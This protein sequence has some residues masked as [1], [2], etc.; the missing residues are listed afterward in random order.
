MT[1]T[2]TASTLFTLSFNGHQT[3]S[4]THPVSA[5]DLKTALN[6]LDTVGGVDVARTDHGAGTPL[7]TYTIEFMPMDSTESPFTE[8]AIKNFGNVP[9]IAAGVD[10][11]LTFGNAP[12]TTEGESPFRANIKYAALSA[13]HTTAFDQNGVTDYD[14]LDN[15]RYQHNT[16]FNI[17]ARDAFSNEIKDE[18]LKEVQIIETTATGTLGG[19]F[20]VSFNGQSFSL[21]FKAGINDLELAL[22]G[23]EG[24]GAVTVT[25]NS[26]NDDSGLDADV[27]TGLDTIN[28]GTTNPTT[29]YGIGDWIR[30]GTGGEVFTVVSVTTSNPFV[31]TVS[32]A[33]SGAS[34]TGVDMLY[35]DVATGTYKGY[36]Y[37]V[38]FD[39]NLGDLEALTVDST[40][41]T[42]AGADVTVTSCN[43]YVYQT[44]TTDSTGAD[45]NGDIGGTFYLAYNGETTADLS[46]AIS[47][48]DLV[49]A[50][51]GLDSIY[52]VSVTATTPDVENAQS[53]KITF[54]AVA[55]GTVQPLYAEGHL[56]TTAGEG[57]A[58][59]TVSNDPTDCAASA[60]S[61]TTAT[62]QAGRQG[63]N[64]VVKL[65]GEDTASGAVSHKS[66][67]VYTAIYNSPK[68]GDYSMAV[69]AAS[70]GGLTGEY[71]NNRWLFG[72]PVVTR[73][74][75]TVDFSWTSD[76]IITPTGKD[77]ISV[78]WT[79][80]IQAAF[81]EVYTFTVEGNDGARLWINDELLFDN[82]ETEVSD[83]DGFST[84]TGTTSVTLTADMLVDI[85]LEYRENTGSAK[86]KLSWSSASQPITV[87]PSNRLF[88]S[89][90]AIKSS[91]FSVTPT[92]IEPTAPTSCSL[93]ISAWNSVLVSWDSPAN[94]GGTGVTGYTVEWWDEQDGYGTDEVQELVFGDALTGS[95]VLTHNG[96]NSIPVAITASQDT[97]ATVIRDFTTVGE[98]SVSREDDTGNNLIKFVI[99][100]TSDSGDVSAIT[101]DGS[102]L[103]ATDF[104]ACDDAAQV[105]GAG[106]SVGC[107]AGP[108]YVQGVAGS[109]VSSDTSITMDIAAGA[110]YE[111]TIASA[112]QDSAHAQ[113]FGVRVFATN[114]VGTGVPCSTN[115]LK[116]M[117]VPD[118]PA[119]V[120]LN[121]VAGQPTS[122]NVHFTFVEYPEDR[123]SAVTGFDIIYDTSADFSSA[124]TK[125]VTVS[126][127]S[128]SSSRQ[129]DIAPYATVGKQY[130]TYTVTGLDAGTVYYV[131]VAATNAIGSGTGLAASPA[132]L[133]PGAQP[134]ALD[135]K[136][137]VS[138]TTVPAD[139]SVTVLESS[140]S[141]LVSFQAPDV[142]NGFIPEKYQVEWWSANP[143]DEIAT[144][145]LTHD[146]NEVGAFSI[147]YNGETTDTM[148]V[149]VDESDMEKE[150][151][152]LTSIRS[153]H[154]EH[155][156]NANSNVWTV[157]FLSETPTVSNKAM[158]VTFNTK[159]NTK[160]HDSS[161]WVV[162]HTVQT[163]TVAGGYDSGLVIVTDATQSFFTYT[164]TGLTAGTPYFVRVSSFNSLGYSVPQ[165]SIPTSLAPPMQN[166][167]EPIST[168]V[169]VHS[170]QALKVLWNHPDSNG[171]DTI[172]KYK[173]EWDSFASF[174]SASGSPLGSHTKILSAPATDCIADSCYYVIG[175]L[176]KGTDYYVRVYAFNSY[177]YSATAGTPT[178]AFESPKTSADPPASVTLTPS[179][180]SSLAVSFPATSDNGGGTITS[181]KVEWDVVSHKADKTISGSTDQS[182]LYV[183]YEVQTVTSVSD[184]YDLTGGFFLAHHE[185]A[186]AQ[187]SVAASANEVKEALEALPSIGT[188][189]VSRTE[190]LNGFTW[191]ITF[192]TN[193]GHDGW[194]GNVGPLSVST[195]TNAFAWD[196]TNYIA[197][198]AAT[199]KSSQAAD[200]AG[201]NNVLGG[202]NA[203]VELAVPVHAYNGYEQ[204]KITSSCNTGSATVGGSFTLSFGGASTNALSF[205]ISAADLEVQLEALG[206]TGDVRVGR[207]YDNTY[208]NVFS[209]S[210]YVV[211]LEKLGNQPMIS[212]DYSLVTCSAGTANVVVTEAK[213]GFLPAMDSNYKGE[214]IVSGDAISGS[215]ITHTIAS[216]SKD[217]EYH[218]RVS[219]F[220]G[221]GST[222][223]PT[224]Y[225]TPA[226]AA[227]ATVP[228]SPSAVTVKAA[229]DA[230]VKVG[231]AAPLN[232][233]GS[234]VTKYKVEWDT[235]PGSPEVQTITS[236]SDNTMYGTFKLTFKTF[237][238]GAIPFDS[239]EVKMKS[240]LEALQSV[241]SVAVSRSSA[242]NGYVWTVTFSDNVGDQP[243]LIAD[244]SSLGGSN[245]NVVVSEV[246][247]GTDP[248]FDQGT[249]GI[250]T[251]PLGSSEVNAPSEVQKIKTSSLSADVGGGF[252][253]HFM[254]QQSTL[255]SYDADETA[256]KE[257][258]ESM[259]TVVGVTVSMADVSEST[260]PV[261]FASREWS[262]TFTGHTGDLP[263]LLVSTVNGAS[264]PQYPA[265]VSTGGT[266]TGTGATVKVTEV[267]A[268]SVPSTFTTPVSLS[269]GTTHF[270][271]VSSYNAVGWSTASVA[272]FGVAPA[273]T[274]PTVP[275]NVLVSVLST[276]E[277]AVSWEAPAKTGGDAVV[278]YAIQW[279]VDAN[280]DSS[281]ST[282]VVLAVDGQSS[283]ST[284]LS[285]LSA[286]QQYAVRVLAYNNQG[287]SSS[288]SAVPIEF[289][290]EV[291][292]FGFS[293]TSTATT[294]DTFVVQYT[295]AA[296]TQSQ[297]TDFNSNT[298]ISVIESAAALEAAMNALPNLGTVRVTRHDYSADPLGNGK[299]IDTSVIAATFD[300]SDGA[301]VDH[302]GADEVTVSA[303]FY[304][305]VYTGAP[306]S[307]GEGGGTVITNLAAGDYFAI[308]SGTANKI[309]FA[310]TLADANGGTQVDLG[311]VGAGTAHTVTLTVLPFHVVY[312]V[313]FVGAT[314]L[315]AGNLADN[316]LDI[317]KTGTD[318]T[319]I[320]VSTI[321]QGQSSATSL[322]STPSDAI[323]PSFPT[324]VALS[325][326]SKKELG[327]T[328]SAPTYTGGAPVTK[329]LV[330]WDTSYNIAASWASSS[331]DY[332]TG[333]AY[334]FS[335]VVTGTSFQITD[336]NGLDATTE[337]WTNTASKEVSNRFDL[338]WKEAN[339]DANGFS[340]ITGNCASN[341]GYADVATNYK[342][343]Y[344]TASDF[345]S[346]LEYSIRMLKNTLEDGT[347]DD[348]AKD[349]CADATACKFAF[350]QEVQSFTLS[351]N[352]NDAIDAGTFKMVY[353]GSQSSSIKVTP[354]LNSATVTI[355]NFTNVE[356]G[357]RDGVDAGDYIRISGDLY[358]VDSVASATY[359]KDITTLTL[360]TAYT[361]GDSGTEVT[362]NFNGP[363]GSCL[364]A[365]ATAMQMKMHIETQLNSAPFDEEV[366]VS[367][368]T[369]SSTSHQYRI[370]YTGAGYSSGADEIAF[371]SNKSPIALKDFTG[372]SWACTDISASGSLDIKGEVTT[373]FDAGT[374]VPGTT[375]YVKLAAVNG[376]G[377]GQSA[378]AS[379]AIIPMSLPG[380]TKNTRVYSIDDDSDGLRITWDDVDSDHGSTITG[381]RVIA[382]CASGACVPGTV[383]NTDIT[384]SSDVSTTTHDGSDFS[385]DL[386]TGLTAGDG[387]TI[388]VSATNSM[389]TG[390]PQW[391]RDFGHGITLSTGS[392]LSPLTDFEVSAVNKQDYV[393]GAAFAV[394]TCDSTHTECE[395][396]YDSVMARTIVAR[397]VPPAPA[398]W[399]VGTYPTVATNEG[400]TDASIYVTWTAPASTGGTA[401]DKYKV[402]WDTEAVISPSNPNYG[403]DV[404]TSGLENNVT[405]LT[406][407][408]LYYIKVTAHN[409]GGYGTSSTVLP[410]TPMQSS[411]APYDPT[412]N[413]LTTV[414]GSSATAVGTSLKVAWSA[415]IVDTGNNDLV[416]TGGDDIT[417]YRIE[418]SKVAWS[419]YTPAVQEISVE[420]TSGSYRLRFNTEDSHMDLLAVQ[421]DYTSE[422]IAFDASQ[423]AME[424]ALQ[425][426]PN[427][428]DVSVV[429]SGSGSNVDPY[430]Y[431]ITFNSE[432]GALA[433]LVQVNVDTVTINSISTTTPGALPNNSDFDSYELDMA[434]HSGDLEYT[435]ADIV[436]GKTY[437]VRVAAKNKMGYSAWRLTAPA[438]R[439]VPV[440]VPGT[441]TSYYHDGSAPSLHVVS[442]TSMAV[443]IGPPNFDGGDTISD[444][445]IEW[446]P[447][448]SFSGSAS[449]TAL[450]SAR[451]TASRELCANCITKFNNVTNTFTYDGNAD[452]LKDMIAQ[453][454]VRVY[455]HQDGS[456]SGNG[457]AYTFS[458]ASATATTFTVDTGHLR[459]IKGWEIGAAAMLDEAGGSKAD[460]ILMGAEYEITGLTAGTPYYVRV[461]A[462]NPSGTG[463]TIATVPSKAT[464]RAAPTP[465]TS[466]TASVTGANSV[467]VAFSPASI[468]GGSIE[469]Y[470]VEYFTRSK[471]SSATGN[472]FGINEIQVLSVAR[473]QN[474]Y[475]EYGTY[476]LKLGNATVTLPYTAKAVT[477]QDYLETTNDFTPY[478]MRGDVIEINGVIY[479]ISST[480]NFHESQ[481][482]LTANYAGISDEA[483]VIKAIPQT[484]NLAH[485]CEDYQLEAA[486]ENLDTVGD[487]DV[488]R[489]VDSN[490][491]YWYTITFVSDL[492]QQPKLQS[493][494]AGLLNQGILMGFTVDAVGNSYTGDPTVV[495]SA[496]DDP[497]GTQAVA[498]VA[499]SSAADFTS[500]VFSISNAG[501]GY[502][503]APTITFTGGGGTA[504]AATATISKSGVGVNDAG[505]GGVVWW[506]GVA[507][508]NY[509]T[510]FV[511]AATVASNGYKI[512]I[513]GL[514]TGEEYYFRV[515][516]KSDRGF[517]SFTAASA[518]A[519]PASEPTSLV[520]APML[521]TTSDSS[522]MVTFE[523]DA[524]VNGAA[525]TSYTVEFDTSNAFASAQTV[526]SPVTHKIQRV[527]TSAHT[528]SLG[529]T[530]S[531]SLGDYHGDFTTAVGGGLATG[532]TGILHD[533]T[534]NT[535]VKVFNG[536][537]QVIR[538]AATA[539]PDKNNY[540]SANLHEEVQRGDFVRVGG[541]EF[542]VCLDANNG[543]LYDADNLPLCLVNDA[544]TEAKYVAP[545]KW[546]GDTLVDGVIYTLD[547]SLGGATLPSYGEAF[548]TTQDAGSNNNDVTA[549]VNRGDLIRVGHPTEGEIFRVSTDGARNF[550]AGTLPLASVEDASVQAAMT[551]A[552]LK[553]ATYEVQTLRLRASGST[554][555]TLGSVSASG[556]RLSYAGETTSTTTAGGASGCILWDAPV[557]DVEAELETLLNIDDVVVTRAVTGSSGSALGWIYSI[558]F[559]GPLVRGDVKAITLQDAGTNGCFDGTVFSAQLEA[560]L[561]TDNAEKAALPF[562]KLQTTEAI[563]VT[564]SAHD[565]KMAI[566][567][568]SMACTV[569]VSKSVVKN[570][571]AWDVTFSSDRV[572]SA[573]DYTMLSAMDANG[574]S[575]TAPLSKSVSVVGLQQVE[576]TGL[577]SGIS[578]F[579]RVKATNGF[580]TG[581]A[582]ASNPTSAQASTQVPSSPVSV[583]T[584]PV[585]D[586]EILVSWEAPTETGGN[587]VT[588]YK[589]E[590]DTTS[591]FDTSDYSYSTVAASATTGVADVQSISLS[592]SDKSKYVAGT[593]TVS[594]DGQ[595]TA[596]LSYD[597]TAEDMEAALEGLCTLSDV[598]VTRHL[599][600]ST[601]PGKDQCS[602]PQGYTWLVTFS[603]VD[604]PGDQ[605]SRF[606]SSLQDAT[607]HKLSV[608]ADNLL[609]CSDASRAL[610]L[611]RNPYFD[612][613]LVVGSIPEV[614][615]LDLG[616]STQDITSLVIMGQ[617]YST[618]IA[619]NAALTVLED[620]LESLSQVGDVT[621]TCI[622]TTGNPCIGDLLGNSNEKV[623]ITYNNL[624]GDVP[625]V[626]V[627]KNGATIWATE[628][629]KGVSQDVVGVST[630]STI[631]SNNVDG[632]DDFY[633]RVSAQNTVGW[634]EASTSTPAF[635][636]PYIAAP[637]VPQSVA[638]TIT[639]ST[640]LTVSWEAPV[641]SGQVN[642]PV[643]NYKIEWD[644][645]P[646]FRTQCH[647]E[648]CD[649]NLL[650]ALGTSGKVTESSRDMSSS[651][652]PV[653]DT[654]P[655]DADMSK[656]KR[657]DVTALDGSIFVGGSVTISRAT[658]TVD[659]IGITS[660]CSN[661][662]VLD[663]AYEGSAISS[664]VPVTKL[665]L[666]TA[667]ATYSYTVSDLVPGVEY[668]VRVSAESDHPVSASELWGPSAFYGYPSTPMAVAPVAVPGV[669][670]L[671]LLD[672]DSTTSLRIDYLAPNGVFPEGSNGAPITSYKVELATATDESATFS[673][674]SN[675]ADFTAGEFRLQ[676]DIYKT[677]CIPV[678]ASEDIV[679]LYL[680][681]LASVDSVSVTRSSVG[682]SEYHY[683]VVFD[684]AIGS[685]GNVGNLN[686]TVLYKD[687]WCEDIVPSTFTS[688]AVVTTSGV[689]GAINEVV[690]ISTDAYSNLAGSFDVSFDFEGD[691][692]Q[693][694]L[695][696]ATAAGPRL[697]SVIA[698]SRTI[699]SANDISTIINAHDK[700]KI[701]GQTFTVM[702][703]AG[704]GLSFTLSDY[705][706]SGA[707]SVPVYIM[708]NVI[709]MASV[710]NGNA[711]LVFATPQI[712]PIG[713]IGAD[714]IMIVDDTTGI[715]YAF[716]TTA[717]SDTSSPWTVTLDSNWLPATNSQVTVYKRKA[718]RVPSDVSASEM[719][720]FVEGLPSIGDVDISRFGP[721]AAN[722]YTWSVT[723]NSMN[724]PS[725]ALAGKSLNVDL[726][727][728]EYF[729]VGSCID[730]DAD[731]TYFRDGMLN[732]KPKYSQLDSVYYI[733][734]KSDGTTWEVYDNS[735]AAISADGLTPVGYT[736]GVGTW[737][738]SCV[739]AA[740]TN[741]IDLLT[742]K[743]VSISSTVSVAG[744][745]P[746]FDNIVSSTVN[747]IG[748]R[749]VHTVK[750]DATKDDING[751][752]HLR[753][754]HSNTLAVMHYDETAD[755]F[756]TKLE[757]LSTIG[758]VSVTRTPTA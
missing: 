92:G 702:T 145:T 434:T 313:T 277:L 646:S 138:L 361:G 638:V 155:A 110:S 556:Y 156:L 107:T 483:A 649:A 13:A 394:P 409:S 718:V 17:Q 235:N 459:K 186:T 236:S 558:T 46:Y 322:I 176:T 150:L 114:A 536:T 750:V 484:T 5:G 76:D 257:A 549:K 214:A 747:S 372:T 660:I 628:H 441:P 429:R 80:F 271:R 55:S 191:A 283:Y 238:T 63:E 173:I 480:G 583:F 721:N 645:E 357:D 159:D 561:I 379:T 208:D 127:L 264:S 676:S 108:V 42:G 1:I 632:L 652:S 739:V 491:G 71:F 597:A 335:A 509:A 15:A 331:N 347:A 567:D 69:E 105:A 289:Y 124:E 487:V 260:A 682:A 544:W 428:G 362:A 323:V 90:E 243:D 420:G 728:S 187:I 476:T 133:A 713:I 601:E 757:A 49:T 430:I 167:S 531:L 285:S 78:R 741:A 455:F 16:H 25:T 330:E 225:S 310:S 291:Q 99:T 599:R 299:G 212:A 610:T 697:V 47:D 423:A 226:R 197:A 475:N 35:Q 577:L 442:A 727:T 519:T 241:G 464:P 540:G 207:K 343:Y 621:V 729:S 616:T 358:L 650:S 400:F 52:S 112:L 407:G 378:E 685:N 233:G 499:L 294:A 551:E 146:G 200:L 555:L 286:G 205:D 557:A 249:V 380:L 675:G 82:Y 136:T 296:G 745:A 355:S 626:K 153:V 526:T 206:T 574:V 672:V 248:A 147:T 658:Y 736:P 213:A 70:V 416:G 671:A 203:Y 158:T 419:S 170:G 679:E 607:S 31:M 546:R 465:P 410:A 119:A 304:D 371:I 508:D 712:S 588:T 756:K 617:T 467:D 111:Y 169:V 126:S 694:L 244:K 477:G 744:V 468:S 552:S 391:Y 281:M 315:A 218:V 210:W 58:T 603:S 346:A 272:A 532:T 717:T 79:G 161:D 115:I 485:D 34:A 185:H 255:I 730:G 151:M 554:D 564:A 189:S 54:N 270:V 60:V 403:S 224:M 45:P 516:A 53:W 23:V 168:E 466:V 670:Q 190:V 95:F 606:L 223:G 743:A 354:T 510:S 216:L 321:R 443:R 470:K 8:E 530:F 571:F 2:G 43:W 269:T 237:T 667:T 37:I 581:A 547:T 336:T 48:A 293:K 593:F 389:G 696:P 449:G 479:T 193:S 282:S 220:N 647:G 674:V 232:S 654:Y 221:V 318:S 44:V 258:I 129:H 457:H 131:K 450:G 708:D 687:E 3:A 312:K 256:M 103:S 437:Y 404:V 613:N 732:G 657:V 140:S 65:S 568:L 363:P 524:V 239:S 356:S 444:F 522:L 473:A 615:V 337:Y 68:A 367:K 329:Y 698:G 589:V 344:D 28:F 204:Q 566:E 446:D 227:A 128:G 122:L 690:T 662:Y 106:A 413:M 456:G 587:T 438:S 251:L 689:A 384:V 340:T 520:T 445:D 366:E 396:S 515:S 726:S 753:F 573:F 75:P 411:D 575:M 447:S 563:P 537:S 10:G 673:L 72:S 478:V 301:V 505:S 633:V 538:V 629:M 370:T 154:V 496:P 263:S 735:G 731:G 374:I 469:S 36:Q 163:G 472:F 141:L 704:D 29:V 636:R 351:S 497:A 390:A 311:G 231:W 20:D 67:G 749:E 4:L 113:G 33:Y 426:M 706:K 518:A 653:T 705:H 669:P 432:V 298:P 350:G 240:S 637:T 314:E 132:S 273:L 308:K 326:V 417:A 590:W 284:V 56:L 242:G 755:D 265:T 643:D 565:V 188:V 618:A 96:I 525:V 553:H 211:F 723:F 570:G 30:V 300:G 529:G 93:S 401:I 123:A 666:G 493:S 693:V 274:V 32:G 512:P 381:Y 332:S 661:C 360:T 342:V 386:T 622:E 219:A 359:N 382:T 664:S 392:A 74:D 503:T 22:E 195:D 720:A 688:S 334:E 686:V 634:S 433:D 490:G 751:E 454:R 276:T 278:K 349:C 488:K 655:A 328:W 453:R 86:V 460:L 533:I 297:L 181:Y 353:V 254:G 494:D 644:T 495:I 266:L 267:T 611:C 439:S 183:P 517:G 345:S 341:V 377:E 451:V 192:D 681:E 474:Y 306:I 418:W 172:T 620:A 656:R 290:E 275:Q 722:G 471:S 217:D 121:R 492:G 94:D 431:T 748:A 695:D 83:V 64:F 582:K 585:S 51:E 89:S 324:D 87:V 268:G 143:T 395:E 261:A 527:K 604:Y 97:V 680:E 77:Y 245:A 511:D 663:R 59:I 600:C 139:G 608:N 641:S 100:F 715:E 580:G 502:F 184:A 309:A 166:P 482:P 196:A 102:G 148:D 40:S 18:P 157:T 209:Y 397:A 149:S 699:T 61:G 320:A 725:S 259:S 612:S 692:E 194:L 234:D 288:S 627:I 461:N 408:Q 523:E 463:P 481:L 348:A 229:S 528:A 678:G 50:L 754:N 117:A 683:T 104:I 152:L 137:G 534:N 352:T 724:G 338:T 178:P 448:S 120:E 709:G 177:G 710:T 501:S 175:G 665:F 339:A 752:F 595:T 387:Y 592:L 85:K 758:S 179:S 507:P 406:M 307:Y 388:Q 252:Y 116:P 625:P 486:L 198:D 118:A 596:D 287:Y 134:V 631:V 247:A 383:T 500:A 414:D 609:E 12:A 91:P 572:A 109:T 594:F 81:A 737:S 11:G 38:T 142:V 165:T 295:D 373:D 130:Y 174:D 504:A 734:V 691:Y 180:D 405:P 738:S 316:C 425:N 62:S 66:N 605:H 521:E 648:D 375:Y 542:R 182:N 171:G 164:I 642:T 279:D 602:N 714:D 703:V 333:T 624:R 440:Q 513:T 548:L 506:D 659:A 402:E 412:L 427:I 421:G 57:I 598:S 489:A 707:A 368:E 543:L 545:A 88:S 740:A 41:L 462:V 415:P 562:Y 305:A 101:V 458:I 742:G 253:A 215:T 716:S 576:I 280:F 399:Q 364:A 578:Y 246:V 535:F 700:V 292:T 222:Y 250:Y 393:T 144:I 365:G 319:L 7:Y 541:Q 614:Q 498:T 125:S 579:T 162:D 711:N 452:M 630:Y 435:I 19:S 514:T 436:P 21:N 651:A 201:G 262:I 677:R 303:A 160:T 369:L 539:A 635:V 701:A 39:S 385:Y 24:V 640:S 569:D 27:T 14:G 584:E 376:A 228:D 230:S 135:A 98:V 302:A 684:G 668:Y 733:A 719:E 317:T 26:A 6:G 424:T 586:G 199:P 327:L 623:Y 9:A 325:V 398:T 73:V 591:S 639:S 202:T 550:N 746:S 422:A 84:F 619:Y 560:P 559:T